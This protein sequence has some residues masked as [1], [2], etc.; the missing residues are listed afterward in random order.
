MK[1]R[2]VAIILELSKDSNMAGIAFFGYR[3]Y[4]D[5]VKVK[6]AQE[7]YLPHHHIDSIEPEASFHKL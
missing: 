6:L 3:Q 7:N 4:D 2:V 1:L 5:P